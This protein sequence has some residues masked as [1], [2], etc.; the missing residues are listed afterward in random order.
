MIEN[1]FLQLNEKLDKLLDVTQELLQDQKQK[2][3]QKN[4]TTE[5]GIDF[6]VEVIKVYKKSTIYKM[7]CKG[8]IPC[9]KRGKNLWFEGEKLEKWLA[10]GMPDISKIPISEK[11][12][13]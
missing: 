2:V 5:G 13:K 7:A 11:L 3:E 1:P 8:Q 12:R 4:T 6:A 10:Q 9:T